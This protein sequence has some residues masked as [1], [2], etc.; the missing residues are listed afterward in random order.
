M[1]LMK[2]YSV[3][4]LISI[5]CSVMAADKEVKKPAV[6]VGGVVINESLQRLIEVKGVKPHYDQCEEEVDKNSDISVRG[7]K[8][9]KC[10]WAKIEPNAKLKEAVLKAYK[11]ESKKIEPDKS[12]TQLTQTTT[13]GRAPASTNS[14]NLISKNNNVS[15]DYASDPAVKALSDFFGKKLDEVLNPSKALTKEEIKNGVILTVDHKKFIELYKSE[16]GKTIISAFTSYCLDTDTEAYKCVGNENDGFSCTGKVEIGKDKKEIDENRT[17]NMKNLKTAN[18]DDKSKESVMWKHCI[19]KVTP[20]CDLKNI[21]TET[22]KRACLIVD[23]VQSAKQNIIAADKQIEDYKLL[24]GSNTPQIEKMKEIIDPNISSTDAL[25]TITSKDVKDSL[26]AP[27]EKAIK[28]FESCYKEDKIVDPEACKK[29]LNTN[30]DESAKALVEMQMRQQMQEEKLDAALNSSDEKVI[31]YLKQEGFEDKEIEKL[32]KNEDAVKKARQEIMDR[33]RAQKAAI[34]KEMADKIQNTVSTENG[35]ITNTE[36]DKT[37]L[38]KIGIELSARKDDL[39]NLVQFNNIVSSYI[40]IGDASGKDKT[41]SRNTASLFAETNS[42]DP[43]DS[44]E[45][46]VNRDK[47]KLTDQKGKAATVGLEVKSI[48]ENLIDYDFQGNNKKK[49]PSERAPA[50]N[51][52]PDEEAP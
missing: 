21:D 38:E 23:Y 14:E 10:L 22:S 4:F 16:L 7:P 13:L 15:N 9:F 3:L 49:D 34:I 45:L 20:N 11:E 12:E 17:K 18:L 19:G 52:K 24:Q 2:S 29:Y 31:D 28:D 30:T 50:E 5:S 26:K 40:E 41:T 35:K 27:S 39:S 33:F 6:A 8:V 42:M 46:I 25:L 43:V 32:T 1:G 37:K 51:A 48:N 47:A 44:K 36:P